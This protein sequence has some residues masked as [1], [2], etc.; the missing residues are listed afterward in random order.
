MCISYPRILERQWN[1]ENREI[2]RGAK[3]LISAIL[4]YRL[5]LEANSETILEVPLKDIRTEDER[6]V[7]DKVQALAH[8]LRC[9]SL[10]LII[11]EV[12]YFFFL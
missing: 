3:E 7:D 2:L 11:V 1:E 8:R 12:A 9:I 5:V 10:D 6:R 4:R